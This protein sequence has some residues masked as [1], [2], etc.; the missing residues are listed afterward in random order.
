QKAKP[1]Y[2]DPMVVIEQKS[3]SLYVIGE[4]N[5]AVSK[6]PAALSHISRTQGSRCR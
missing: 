6:L 1:Q 3:D 4:L 2:P 5:G